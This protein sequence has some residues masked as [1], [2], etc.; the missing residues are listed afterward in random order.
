MQ[1]LWLLEILKSRRQNPRVACSLIEGS[2][3]LRHCV[4]RH[5]YSNAFISTTIPY[6]GWLLL[7]KWL[8]YSLLL[9]LVVFFFF[10]SI[11]DASGLQSLHH[12]QSILNEATSIQRQCS[13]PSIEFLFD[14]YFHGF[15]F[16]DECTFPTIFACVFHESLA[17]FVLVSMWL[18]C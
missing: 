6:I 1:E 12:Q 15:F 8:I 10:L 17:K 9:F 16:I 11:D 14:L 18:W 13:S 7:D 5:T 4:R 2:H 3:Q